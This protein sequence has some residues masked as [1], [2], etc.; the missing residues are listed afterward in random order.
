MMYFTEKSKKRDMSI[1]TD[2]LVIGSGIGGLSTALKLAEQGTVAIITKKQQS[3]SNTNYAQ[4]GI[5]SVFDKGDTYEEHIKDTLTAGA[6]LCHED[7]VRLI[8]E[9]GPSRVQ[10]LFN[11]GVNFTKNDKGQFDLGREGGHHH[12]RIVHV[13]D[14]TGRD[15]EAALLE[16]ARNNPRV[17]I[18]ENHMAVELITE[19]HVFSARPATNLPI[20][21]WGAYVLDINAEKIELFIAK[22]TILASGGCGQVYLHTTNPSIATGD[23]V[24]IA[25]R[26]GAIIANMEFMQFHP[27]SL[28]HPDANSFLI[29][30]AVRGFGGR[31]IHKDGESFMEKYHPMAAL[32][33]RD[34]VARAIDTELKKRGVPCVYLDVSHLDADAIRNRFPN[35]YENCLRYKI[36]ITKEPIPVVPAAHYACGGV[37]TD[38]SGR[39]SIAGLYACGEVTCT[40]V[41]G[42]NRLAS[43]SLLEAVVF[44][45]TA[46]QAAI[47]FA[48]SRKMIPSPIPQWDDSGTFNQEEWVLISH[49]RMEIKNIMWDYVGIVRS[50]ARLERAQSRIR[51]LLQEIENYYKRTR[52]TEG[53]L[54]LRNLVTVAQLIIQSAMMRKESR[55]LHYTTDYPETDDS[56][57]RDTLIDRAGV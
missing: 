7:A 32:A 28:Y 6:G 9:Q 47:Q 10:E 39:T 41:H 30:E 22:A 21:C 44:A 26:A 36:D 12:N 25:F 27:T 4:G 33:P 20:N 43:N 15:V 38:L 23:G 2:F 13:K 19:H 3:E 5:A 50:N 16:A 8:V 31:L 54:E 49:D 29:S 55:G 11:L 48:A 35:I 46:S 45:H 18:Y 14:H 56:Y 37:Q 1:E 17:T 57:R 34:I 42:A 52:V 24:A 40:G 53:L 51:L